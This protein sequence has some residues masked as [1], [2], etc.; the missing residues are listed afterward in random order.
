VP[1]LHDLDTFDQGLPPM[2]PLP[3]S[4]IRRRGDRLRRRRTA[5]VTVGGL[6]AAVAV[7]TPVVALARGGADHSVAPAPQPPAASAP[8][9]GW[10]TTVP[11]DFP[12]TAGFADEGAEPT[13][14]LGQDPSLA[15]ACGSEGFSGFTDNAVVTY[16]GES[17]DRAMRILVLYPDGAAA[18]AELARLREDVADCA[19][20]QVAEGTTMVVTP[21][22]VDLGTEESFA[23]TEQIQHDD[24]LVSD[25]SLFEVARTGNAIYV[26]MS[27]GAAGGDQ[28][29]PG[30][31]KRLKERSAVP[32][33]ALCTFA[34]EPCGS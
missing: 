2:N 26:D 27:Y 9:D 11:D 17:E 7:A 1:D 4:E 23:F 13:G 28:V 12:L 25:L 22:A 10:V 3:A 21:V 14:A 33:G 31:V 29:V 5:A 15:V 19:P 6:L 32:L 34:V 18:E 20:S 8:A 30:E 16:Q 24:G